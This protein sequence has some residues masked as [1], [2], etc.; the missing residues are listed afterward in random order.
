MVLY[1]AIRQCTIEQFNLSASNARR[2]ILALVELCSVRQILLRD[3][4]RR[5][6]PRD[7]YYDYGEFAWSGRAWFI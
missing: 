5:L 7:L 3:Y 2:S 6:A 4:I 1:D